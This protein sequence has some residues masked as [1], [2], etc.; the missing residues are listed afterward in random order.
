MLRHLQVH[1]ATRRLSAVPTTPAE[2]VSL[3]EFMASTE[4]R[5]RQFTDQADDVRG[6]LPHHLATGSCFRQLCSCF[7]AGSWSTICLLVPKFA[8]SRGTGVPVQ[9]LQS[10]GP[11]RATV[12]RILSMHHAF[13]LA[14][15]CSPYRLRPIAHKQS[16]TLLW[17]PSLTFLGCPPA[18]VSA[19]Y[20][21]IK[22]F[23]IA[24]PPIELAAFQMIE[25]DLTALNDALYASEANKE[26]N[27]IRFQKELDAEVRL[28]VLYQSGQYDAWLFCS[29]L[30]SQQG[31]LVHLLSQNGLQLVDTNSKHTAQRMPSDY[32]G[33]LGD[34]HNAFIHQQGCSQASCKHSCACSVLSWP[35]ACD[36]SCKLCL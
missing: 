30:N 22:E 35:P 36:N 26:D 29:H 21:L 28:P 31:M 3:L 16:G 1:G 8:E 6:P 32:E 10:H 14:L 13:P 33:S 9:L 19:H 17:L 15:L 34:V 2:M 20:E 7:H 25:A 11:C 12:T 24:V 27:I 5:R 18:Q 4:Q 23:D